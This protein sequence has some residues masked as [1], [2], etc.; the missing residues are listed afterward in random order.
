MLSLNLQDVQPLLGR[1]LT[2]EEAQLVNSWV[3]VLSEFLNVR[4]G[5]RITPVNTTVF[6]F[7]VAQAVKRMMENPQQTVISQSTESSSVTYAAHS[8]RGDLFLPAEVSQMDLL[9]G[10]QKSS[11]LRATSLK[12]LD[13]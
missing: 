12:I 11:I 5:D 13:Y 9:T 8:T 7:F 10:K 4:Y 3:L 1:N 6:T 2:V